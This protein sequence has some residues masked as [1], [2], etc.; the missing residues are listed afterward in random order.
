[1]M[2][3]P[4]YEDLYRAK[5]D[6]VEEALSARGE[7]EQPLVIPVAVHFQNT[8]I[9]LACAIDMALDQIETLN[10]DFAGT[11]PDITTWNDLQPDIW[12]GISN[13]ESC[14]C[15]CLASLNHPAG[16]GLEDGDYAVTIDETT[17]DF[18]A[19]W[20]GYLNFFVRDIGGGILG[21][22]PLGGSG[23]GDG[24]TVAPAY[25]GSI[26]CG[27][28]TVNPPY[29][30]GRTTTH[31]VGHY[32][33]L[34]H[35][36]GGGGCASNDFVDDTPVTDNPVFGCPGNEL[37]NCTDPV[38]WPSYMDYCDDACLFMF[39][40]GQVARM[41]TYVENNLQNFLESSATVCVEALCQDFE[42]TVSSQDET[43][44]GNDGLINL[45]AEGGA[46]P[47]N[48]SINNGGSFQPQGNFN[49]LVENDYQVMVTDQN[50]C[51]FTVT[52]GLDRDPPTVSIANFQ[53]EY[54]SDASGMIEVD[55][56]G[57]ANF[58]YSVDGV[59]WQ[60]S[61]VFTGLSAGL[62]TV[63]VANNTGC[64]GQVQTVLTNDSDLGYEVEE[65]K[66]VN[67]TW[68]D[69]GRI[70]VVAEGSEGSVT[71]IL[72]GEFENPLGAFE[73]LSPGPHT[74]YM[75][76]SVGCVT[77]YNF[78][79]IQSFAEL[80]EDCPCTIFVPNAFTPDGDNKNDN[81]LVVPSCPLV[82]FEMVIVNRWGE[83]VFRTNS[84]DFRW[85]GG[86][87]GYYVD[88]GVYAY[89]M[90]WRWGN[91]LGAGVDFQTKTGSVAV[92]R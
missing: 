16:W 35:P 32:L 51:E 61:P 65:F 54:C 73:G 80:D 55:A 59:N 48:Y 82:D 28:N 26:S 91:E 11:N 8:G 14:I 46:E 52:V 47:Y 50:A 22:S 33:F 3:L 4:G 84:L 30:L 21:Y 40:A 19:D 92:I 36:W 31:E 90:T 81:L 24:V 6:V 27:G 37:I 18:D 39:S 83:V 74:I 53:N 78:D 86:L 41:E 49:N 5:L 57:S 79:M 75:E 42:V 69:N 1:M 25:F 71:Y 10:Q 76:D 85:N 72:D 70:D 62:Y 66:P 56:T 77:Y 2:G 15:F 23:N 13:A 45:I 38:L 58:E 43:C 68:F 12:P 60:D 64:S 88:S 34:E 9:P 89:Q 29:N 87:G 67:C 44:E 63:Q 17:G 7:C 20:A